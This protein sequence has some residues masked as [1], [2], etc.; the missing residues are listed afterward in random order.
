MRRRNSQRKKIS[1]KDCKI[2]IEGFGKVGS[3][4]GKQFSEIG[5]KIIAVSTVKGAIFNPKGLNISELLKLK[6]M[7]GDD[8]VK[9]YK[10]ARR[11]GKEDLLI[12][13]TDFL[14]PCAYSWS[15]NLSN[16][17]KIKAK[18]I[19]CGANNP[20]TDK[21]K[22]ILVK[23]KILYFPDFVSNCG[24]VLGS[25]MERSY[26]KR[27]NIINFIK[28][29]FQPKV[30][31]LIMLPKIKKQPLEIIAKDIA[32]AN[33]AKMKQKENSAKNKFFS[34]ALKILRQGLIPEALVRIFASIYVK[35]IIN[36]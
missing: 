25:I 26:L 11:I 31:D 7:V 17:K 32:I 27:K 13:S 2:V 3:W 5:C 18:I 29:K 14:I 21:A 23:K 4:V 16:V 1:L 22:E 19:V 35:K 20:V 15:I 34:F 6:E 8:C 12:L 9:N 24:G 28:K 33:F 36:L 30:Q 10:N